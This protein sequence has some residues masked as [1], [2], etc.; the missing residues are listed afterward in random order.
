MVRLK[1]QFDPVSYLLSQSRRRRTRRY[2]RH[3]RIGVM[4][5]YCESRTR[6]RPPIR[7]PYRK[8]PPY[9]L[10]RLGTQQ[11]RPRP[12]R[13][14]RPKK[15]YYG[16]VN[17]TAT[18]AIGTGGCH[19]F[20]PRA[21]YRDVIKAAAEVLEADP[22]TGWHPPLIPSRPRPRHKPPHKACLRA[23]RFSA[24]PFYQLPPAELKWT[25]GRLSAFLGIDG[26]NLGFNSNN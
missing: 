18:A 8:A 4:P 14:G 16:L 11:I 21:A 20:V 9:L 23:R 3:R 13:R 24:L 26:K 17:I 12:Q 5:I 1:T 7:C 19:E 6:V 2:R 10:F 25:F 15:V 22:N